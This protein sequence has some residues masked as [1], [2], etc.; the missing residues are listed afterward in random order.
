M[1]ADNDNPYMFRRPLHF[2][3]RAVDLEKPGEHP[4]NGG[5]PDTTD[6]GERPDE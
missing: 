6:T 1:T 4:A 3:E 5:S 2:V